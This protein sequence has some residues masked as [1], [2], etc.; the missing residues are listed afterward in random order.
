[1]RIRGLTLLL[2]LATALALLPALL[3]LWNLLLFR[4]PPR[5]VPE[6]LAVSVVI[7]ARDE[8]ANIG[9]CVDAARA[10][11]GCMVEIVVVDDHSTDATP[12]IVAARMAADSRVRVVVPPPL[13]SGWAGKP[14]ACWTGAQAAQHPILL[15]IDADVRLGP[16][17]VARL[18]AGLCRER[19]ALASAFPR[20]RTGSLG[21]A[22]LVPLIHVLLLGYL[23]LRLMRRSR[24]PALGA[25][26]GQVMMADAAAYRAIGGHGAVRQS[27]HDGVTLPRAFRTR[28]H[29]TGLFDA[30]AL[31]ECRMYHGWRAAWRGFS[32]NAREG[33]A[34]PGALPVWTLLL[35]GGFVAAPMLAALA[36]WP[37]LLA[38]L[39]LLGAARVAVGVRFRQPPLAVLLTPLAMLAML[40]L[41][42]RALLRRGAAVPVWR[43][44]VQAT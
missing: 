6:G 7:P 10:S 30:T 20:E 18:A 35:G 19:L 24:R 33:L 14:H 15:F 11:A 29:M 43:G 1:M 16:E 21:E 37:P 4:A 3:T 28:G 17:A 38:A 5:S 26:C 31:A 36:P 34:R 40:V 8:A 44:R 9:A 22:L 32:K 25:G 13:P 39:A 27:W 12:A 2:I 23:P 42:W 41:Q